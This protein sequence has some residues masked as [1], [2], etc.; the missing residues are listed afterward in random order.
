MAEIKID[1]SSITPNSHKYHQAQREREKL[2]PVVKKDR[3]VSTKKPLSQKF[4]ETFMLSDK[5]EIR[6]Y[7]LFEKIIPGLKDFLMD[8]MSTIFY[9]S[10]YENRRGSGSSRTDYRSMYDK[11]KRGREREDLT[12]RTSSRRDDRLDYRNIVLLNR[13][14]TE[15]VIINLRRRIEKY[16][17]VSIAELFDLIGEPARQNDENWGWKNERDIGLRRVAKGFLIDVAEAEYLGD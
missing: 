5:N 1:A 8:L 17:S 7:I 4:S 15:E 16:G 11:P 12:R 2:D 6:N 9:G 10:S 14:E 3:I 13:D